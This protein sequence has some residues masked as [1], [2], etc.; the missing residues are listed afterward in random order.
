MY[1]RHLYVATYLRWSNKPRYKGYHRIH[2]YNIRY[3][4]YC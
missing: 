2:I 1:N 3:Y 4:Y